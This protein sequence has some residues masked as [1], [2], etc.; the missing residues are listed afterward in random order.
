MKLNQYFEIHVRK[1]VV[2]PFLLRSHLGEP[3]EDATK[4]FM[5]LQN[6]WPD[7]PDS[8]ATEDLSILKE[9]FGTDFLTKTHLFQEATFVEEL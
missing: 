5:H 3:L 8:L 6:A 7:K 2:A 4:R 9:L 1:F